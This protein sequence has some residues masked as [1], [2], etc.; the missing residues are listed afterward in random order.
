[1]REG[2]ASTSL[3]LKELNLKPAIVGLPVEFKKDDESLRQGMSSLNSAARFAQSIGCPRMGTWI[4]PSSETPKADLRKLYRSRLSAVAS[5]LAQ[6]KVRLALEFVS[7]LHLRK[8][9]PHEFIYRMD[10][11][12]EFAREC[13]PNVGVMLDSWHWHHAGSS[14]SDIVDAGIERIV[15]VQVADAPDVPPEKILD[16][17]RLMPGE[18]MVDFAAFF[19]ALRKIGYDG[20]VSPEV[21]GRGLKDM[22]P[23]EGA[24][25]GLE[26]TRSVMRKHGAL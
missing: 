24:R 2:F 23:E 22:P 21:F 3:L 4:L 1:M 6:S 26:T 19:G 25:L 5:V 18:G 17:E 12:V 16:S 20:G 8:R 11:M 10:E 9:F 13:G 15:H 14:A 7:P